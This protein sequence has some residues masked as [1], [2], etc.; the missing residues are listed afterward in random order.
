MKKQEVTT[1][2]GLRAEQV[3]CNFLKMRG[4]KIVRHNWRPQLQGAGQVDI[5]P[6]RRRLCIFLK[7][8]FAEIQWKIISL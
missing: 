1:V 5:L 3:V 6:N 8:N 2:K 7:L 4:W